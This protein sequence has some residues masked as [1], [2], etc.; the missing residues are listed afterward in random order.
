MLLHLVLKQVSSCAPSCPLV[1]R[2]NL[3]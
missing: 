1:I 3:V 2:I